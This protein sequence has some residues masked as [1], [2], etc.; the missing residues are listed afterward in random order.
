MLVAISARGRK[1]TK[2]SNGVI[3][4][5]SWGFSGAFHIMESGTPFTYHFWLV[6]VIFVQIWSFGEQFFR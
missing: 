5:A 3:A 4:T 1:P 2:A 6:I